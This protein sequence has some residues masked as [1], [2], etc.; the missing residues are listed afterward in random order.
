MFEDDKM[1]IDWTENLIFMRKSIIFA[2]SY[3]YQIMKREFQQTFGKDLRTVYQETMV[4]CMEGKF[5]GPGESKLYKEE[6][7]LEAMT[8]EPCETKVAV[9][10]GDCLEVGKSMLDEGLNP[11]VLNMA[12]AFRPG[13]GVINGARAQEECI[14]RRSN[15]FMSLYR[16]DSYHNLIFETMTD[17]FADFGMIEQGYPMDENFGGIYS[18]NVTVFKDGNYDRMEDVYQTAFITVAALNI[19]YAVRFRERDFLCDGLLNDEAIR[20]TK[21]KIRTIYRIGVLHGHDSLVLGAWGCGAFGNPPE[22]MAQLF[23]EVLDED[24]FKGRYKDI[25]FAIIEDHNSRGRNFLSFKN[26][27]SK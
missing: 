5:G 24:E 20:I 6:V 23:M 10:N 15:L 12:N 8:D 16:Y 26:V 9:V 1:F 7:R 13:G 3:R 14:F 22:Q 4:E 18:G 11:A 21:N 17:D 25:R 19:S 27:I 2:Q